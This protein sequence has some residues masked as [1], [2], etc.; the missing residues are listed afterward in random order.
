MGGPNQ[1]VAAFDRASGKLLWKNGYFGGARV[2]DSHRRGQ[3]AGNSSCSA[4]T[5]SGDP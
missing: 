2:A 1:A 4:A 5:S 3:T